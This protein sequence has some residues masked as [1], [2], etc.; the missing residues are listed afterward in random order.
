VG[1]IGCCGLIM[2]LLLCGCG[3]SS[4]GS[5]TAAKTAQSKRKSSLETIPLTSS[6]VHKG[7][8]ISARYTCDGKDLSLPLSWRDVPA[9]TA[10]LALF[11]ARVN[12][13]QTGAAVIGVEWGVAGLKPTLSGVAAG[14]LPPGAIVARNERGKSSYSLCPTG[15][16]EAVYAV[17]LYAL[18]HR[19]AVKP[20]VAA[21]ALRSQVEAVTKVGGAMTFHYKRPEL[22]LSSPVSLTPIP[23]RYTCDGGGV[24][25]P[26]NWSN[27]PPHTAEYAAYLVINKPLSHGRYT[28]AWALAGIDRALHGIPPGVVPA[29]AVVGHNSFGKNGYTVCPPKGTSQKYVLLLF[30]LKHPLH[31]RTGFDAPALLERFAHA[32]EK[33]KFTLATYKRR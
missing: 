29:G 14:E 23:A 27:A 1:K 7:G 6:V 32:S 21:A 25:L 9:G 17:L 10:E 31:V 5:N 15:G 8:T 20:S 2:A 13:T 33:V 3:S 30:A 11:L 16:G 24:S 18:P 22:E 28:V 19:I 12:A 4:S 26:L